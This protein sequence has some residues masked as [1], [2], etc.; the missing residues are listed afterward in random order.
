MEKTKD[1]SNPF[2]TLTLAKA[3]RIRFYRNG[4]QYFPGIVLTVSLEH[5]RTIDSLFERLNRVLADS[6]TLP[7]G[8]RYIFTIDG[9]KLI[10]SVEQLQNGHGYV[11][12]STEVFKPLNYLSVR[13]P[14]W[15]SNAS[16]PAPLSSSSLRTYVKVCSAVFILS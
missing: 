1:L 16:K 15:C 3:M 10:R 14:I 5:Y 11:C 12:S 4:D 8:V 13:Q 2:Q 7:H 9:L 6:T